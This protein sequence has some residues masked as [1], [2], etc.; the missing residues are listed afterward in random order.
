ME[1]HRF[2]ISFCEDGTIGVNSYSEI[3]KMCFVAWGIDFPGE[4]SAGWAEGI[5]TVFESLVGL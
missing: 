4:S 2:L 5:H 3:Q 1:V